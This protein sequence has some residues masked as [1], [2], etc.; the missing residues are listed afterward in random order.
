MKCVVVALCALTGAPTL[1]AAQALEPP[2]GDRAITVLRDDLYQVRD[3][4]QH[5]VFLVTPDGIIL[6]DDFQLE[7]VRSAVWTVFGR[8][9]VTELNP[10]LWAVV[11]ASG[12]SRPLFVTAAVPIQSDPTC[13]HAGEA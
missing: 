9:H 1:A 10:S 11:P 3:G 5:T 2:P 7:S 8:G 13:S 6:G 12:S 4:Q